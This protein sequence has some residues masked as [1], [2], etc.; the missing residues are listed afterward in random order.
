MARAATNAQLLNQLRL[1]FSA[2]SHTYY[3]TPSS[4]GPDPT[5]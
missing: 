5:P 4:I 1:R 2:K 3:P